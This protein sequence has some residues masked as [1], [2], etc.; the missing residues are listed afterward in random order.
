MKLLAFE[1]RLLRIDNNEFELEFTIEDTR[2]IDNMAIVIFKFDELIPKYRQFR[3]CRAYDENGI[4]IWIAEHP[5]NV[6]SDFYIGFID[7]K[8]N[9]LWNFSCFVC[10]IDFKSGKIIN[11]NFT[12]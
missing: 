9:N 7:T 1:N 8:S 12:K 2:I 10:E 6:S 4:E 5:T 11:A 3:N